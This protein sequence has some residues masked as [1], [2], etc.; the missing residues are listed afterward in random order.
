MIRKYKYVLGCTS[1]LSLACA[2][3]S[4]QSF[5]QVPDELPNVGSSSMAWADFNNDGLLDM[6]LTGVG[7][8][9]THQ[10][11]IYLNDGDDTFSALGAGIEAVSDGA[12]AVGDINNDG[13]MDILISGQK[14]DGTRITKLYQNEGDGTF[15]TLDAGLPQLAFSDA[16][17]A[18][19]NNDGRGDIFILGVSDAGERKAQ[20]HLNTVSGF[21]AHGQSF[22][23]VSQGSV[24]AKD[25]N[26]DGYIDL[27]YHGVDNANQPALYYYINDKQ[28]AFSQTANGLVPLGNGRAV[29]GDLNQDGYPDLLL[30]GSR[31]G[32]SYTNMYLNNAGST[33]TPYLSLNGT[34][35]ST[36]TFGDYDADGDADLFYSGL[37]GAVF[38]SYLLENDQPQLDGSGVSFPGLSSGKSAF[39]DYNNDGKL[40]IF[41]SGYTVTAPASNLYKN[42][43]AEINTLPTAPGGLSVEVHNDSVIFKW[44]PAADF[45]TTANG[46]TYNLYLG[47]SSKSG[48]VLSAQADLNTGWRRIASPGVMA[49]TFAIV[50]DLAEGQYYWAVQSIDAAHAG[51]PF[52]IEDTFTICYDIVIEQT[53][54]GCGGEVLLEYTGSRPDDIVKW[55]YM[56][57]LVTPFSTDQKPIISPEAAVDVK[58]QVTRSWGCKVTAEATASVNPATTVDSGGDQAICIGDTIQLGGNPTASG[59]LLPYTYQWSPA[60]AMDNPASANPKVWPKQTTTY[61]LVVYAGGCEV[62][63]S[64][65]IVTVN[66]LPMIDAGE[67]VTIGLNETV[68]LWASGG[69]TYS[70]SPSTGLSDSISATPDASPLVTT[71]YTVS[72]T[73]ANGCSNKDSITVQVRSEVFI[74]NLFSPNGDG[75]NDIF[76][77]YGTGVQVIQLAVYDRKGQQLFV[78]DDLANGWDGKFNGKEMPA[79]NYLWTLKG[80][81][82]D[83]RPLDFKGTRKGS[84]RLVR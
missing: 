15:R 31:F 25:F 64:S 33:F 46:L 24:V 78:T 3:L 67:D 73:D 79:G 50:T 13:W 74:P 18:D 40:D 23:G 7:N 19:F 60:T 28:G 59:S 38:K 39:A 62:D 76:Y 34:V 27:L 26:K 12:V 35:E 41:L 17:I 42:I 68:Q 65:I 21:V 66:D 83:G 49:D 8:S 69:V 44:D 54:Q 14:P 9:S 82:Y 6:V 10:S 52:S 84:F 32:T 70:W 43:R 37:E 30:T 56:D 1:L 71:T 58:V 57:D 63:R 47:T 16:T 61:E 36:A 22:E 72:G 80:Q 75:E 11:G 29:A 4:A 5:E 53:L 55:F 45:E 77:A 81:Y 2:G 20:L 48:D 51:S